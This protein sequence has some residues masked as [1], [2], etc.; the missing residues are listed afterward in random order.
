MA[1]IELIATAAFGLEAVVAAELKELGYKDQMV[2][3][4]RV[5]F[6][7]DEEAICRTN[8]WLRSADRVLVKMG[9]FEAVTFD[10][11]FEGTKALP[12]PEWL[13]ADA[14]FPVTGKAVKSKLFSVPDCQAIVKK[15]VV[16]KMKQAYHQNWF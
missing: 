1:K 2:E 5:T 7:G 8:L 9:E 13:P 4:G 10:E 14:A 15:A 16:E 12:W 6:Y 11:L 3:N